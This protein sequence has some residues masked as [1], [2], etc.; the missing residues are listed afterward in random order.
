MIYDK[1]LPWQ[2]ILWDGAD[3]IRGVGNISEIYIFV[4]GEWIKIP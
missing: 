3:I 4:N 1:L 2:K